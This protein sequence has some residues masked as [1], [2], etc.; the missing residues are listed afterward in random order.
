MPNKVAKTKEEI[1]NKAIDNFMS[2]RENLKKI[3]TA[4]S[5][6]EMKE[7]FRSFGLEVT[8]KQL[9]VFKTTFADSMN[10]EINNLPAKERHNLIE[11]ASES[12]LDNTSGGTWG[13][14]RS[15]LGQGINCGLWTG[16]ILGSCVGIGGLVYDIIDAA[17]NP[18]ENFKDQV[19]HLLR[20][21]FKRSLGTALAFTAV[22]AGIGGAA[23]LGIDLQQ[24]SNSPTP[25]NNNR[26]YSEQLIDFMQ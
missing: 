11:M 3:F 17:E 23:G 14:T 7:V 2:D 24:P 15:C 12:E 21:T 4:N 26:P 8:D 16:T 1:A 10:A 13:N 9:D 20:R 19:W 5:Y 25:T 18:G 6:E 22:G